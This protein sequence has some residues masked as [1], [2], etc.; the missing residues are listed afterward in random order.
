MLAVVAAGLLAAGVALAPDTSVRVPGTALRFGM[1]RAQ[2]Q[3][4]VR[5]LPAGA[6][7]ALAGVAPTPGVP[8][9][10]GAAPAAPPVALR[11][12]GL[13]G[14]ATLEFE[15][16]RLARAVVRVVHPSPKAIDYVEDDL[17]RQGYHRRCETR[18]GLNRRC[19]FTGRA[20]VRL[21][22]TDISL[23]AYLLPAA[24]AASRVLAARIQPAGAAATPSALPAAVAAAL[25]AMRGAAPP[26]AAPPETLLLASPGAPRPAAGAAPDSLPVVRVS[27]ACA[28]VR[29]DTARAL[30][31]FGRVLVEVGVD[32][33]GRVVA[34]RIARGVPLLDAAALDCARR[35]RFEPAVWRGRVHPFR[36][37]LP[38]AFTL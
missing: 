38:I 2:V 33:T 37:V 21:T 16:E 26:G 4:L 10:P 14:Q 1:P 20:W 34:A 13:D 23:E 29:P 7:A 30:G 6:S 24:P 11:F 35:Y 9:A 12:F 19:D 32:S 36:V 31:I 22:T 18:D 3:R 8:G 28:A 25:A 27:F 15:S 5:P 17:A